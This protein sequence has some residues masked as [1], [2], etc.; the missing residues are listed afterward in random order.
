MYALFIVIY[1]ECPVKTFDIFLLNSEHP[2]FVR[3]WLSYLAGYTLSA[4]GLGQEHVIFTVG[5]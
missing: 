1:P 4:D 3:L 5:T 2:P